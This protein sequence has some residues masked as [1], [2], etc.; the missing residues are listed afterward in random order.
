MARPKEFD[1][2]RALHRAISIFSRKGFAATSTDDLMR[3]M[4]VGRQSMYDTFGDKRE[5]FLRALEMYVTESR[6]IH[7]RRVGKAWLG[8]LLRPKCSRDLCRTK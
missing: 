8:A 3:A 5:L 4:D 6:P 1:Q 7:Q 2:E